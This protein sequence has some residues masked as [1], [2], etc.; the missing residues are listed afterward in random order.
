M[1]TLGK[2]RPRVVSLLLSKE[3]DID[4]NS[5][6]PKQKHRVKREKTLQTNRYFI[7]VMKRLRKREKGEKSILHLKS[8]DFTFPSSFY[9]RAWT[10]HFVH[11]SHSL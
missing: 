7:S 6:K 5:P 1:I 2:P 9:I 10:W 11:E 3:M 8:E 4:M